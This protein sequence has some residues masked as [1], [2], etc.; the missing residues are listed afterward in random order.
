MSA[1]LKWLPLTLLSLLAATLAAH[2]QGTA[3]KHPTP[4]PLLTS[5]QIKFHTNND[6]LDSDSK[7][8][9]VFVCGNNGIFASAD[10]NTWGQLYA[11]AG[12][13]NN[14]STQWATVPL[15]LTPRLT[16]FQVYACATELVLH[17]VGHDTWRFNY[18]VQMHYSDGTTDAYL[19]ENHALS[20][21]TFYNKYPLSR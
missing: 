5:I 12:F 11:N 16:R 18:Y 2:T 10:G 6:D 8:D 9:I 17:P 3:N 19:F 7:V 21:K 1:T 14:Q 4:D 15:H 13:H 20:E